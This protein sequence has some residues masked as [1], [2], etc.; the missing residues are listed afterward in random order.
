MKIYTLTLLSCF[1]LLSC[2]NQTESNSEAPKTISKN[3]KQ[4]TTDYPTYWNHIQKTFLAIDSIQTASIILN[5]NILKNNKRIKK[6]QIQ[7]F[8]FNADDVPEVFVTINESYVLLFQKVDQQWSIIWEG[9]ESDVGHFPE[10]ITKPFIGIKQHFYYPCSHCSESGNSYFVVNQGAAKE[11]FTVIHYYNYDHETD[12]EHFIYEQANGELFAYNDSLI[13]FK[14]DMKLSIP[15][16]ETILAL[17]SVFISYLWDKTK[18]ELVFHFV[19]PQSLKPYLEYWQNRVQYSSSYAID[20]NPNFIYSD[21]VLKA[22]LEWS[23]QLLLQ[24]SIPQEA[25]ADLE[26][27]YGSPWQ[28]ILQDWSA[29]HSFIA[30]NF[31]S[32]RPSIYVPILPGD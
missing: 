27:W 16:T 14:Y 4:D 2:L 9:Y 31:N 7:Q 23:K 24:Q 3:T 6:L 20:I 10:I 19:T 13:V 32:I 17:D 29:E 26:K 11:V 22:Y 25:I 1:L 15:T 5:S 8:D 28:Q 18:Q 12:G 21:V 30:Y